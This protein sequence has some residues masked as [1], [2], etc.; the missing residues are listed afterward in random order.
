MRIRTSPKTRM[1]PGAF[2]G[3]AV[4]ASYNIHAMLIISLLHKP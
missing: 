2:E 1:K 3:Q 4:P